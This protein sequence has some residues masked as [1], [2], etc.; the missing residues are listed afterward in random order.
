MTS[1]SLKRQQPEILT[2][3]KVVGALRSCSAILVSFAWG[4]IGPAEVAAPLGNITATVVAV[5]LLVLGRRGIQNGSKWLKLKHAEMKHGCI[6][7][8][9]R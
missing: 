9:Q 5:F 6:N 2:V 1:R 8:L 7:V 3:D 4:A